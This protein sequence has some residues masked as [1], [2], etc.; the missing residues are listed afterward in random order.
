MM[1]LTKA[2][3]L[4]KNAEFLR[5]SIGTSGKQT[6]E[7]KITKK[8][9]DLGEVTA[10]VEIEMLQDKTVSL[11]EG[12][13]QFVVRGIDQ[14]LCV[15][16]SQSLCIHMSHV[17]EKE[18]TTGTSIDYSIRLTCYTSGKVF[19]SCTSF[20][21][22]TIEIYSLKYPTWISNNKPLVITGI[23]RKVCENGLVQSS[24]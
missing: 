21:S 24:S 6:L 22:G 7:M 19:E 10:Y 4:A 2:K 9:K 3:I 20:Y 8:D 15:L 11:P 18:S 16:N 14:I 1:T 12:S 5:L 17:G 13:T 23:E